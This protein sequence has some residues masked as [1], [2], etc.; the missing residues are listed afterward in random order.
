MASGGLLLALGHALDAGA[1]DLGDEGAGV[2]DET[3]D[4]RHELGQDDDAALEVE[5][6]QLRIGEVEG[7]AREEERD[8]RQPDDQ[9][10]RRRARSEIARP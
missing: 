2:D 9:P 7:R 5:A 6:A 3:D 4:Q 1:D 8:H 10:Q